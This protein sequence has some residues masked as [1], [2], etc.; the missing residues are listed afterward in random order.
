MFRKVAECFLAVR[1]NNKFPEDAIS[2]RVHFINFPEVWFY[3]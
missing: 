1:Q 2:M 3:I